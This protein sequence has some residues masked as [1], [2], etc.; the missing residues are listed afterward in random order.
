[1]VAM[2]A[3]GVCARTCATDLRRS[4]FSDGEIEPE[5]SDGVIE[6]EDT[7]PSTSLTANTTPDMVDDSSGSSTND[8][9]RTSS[10][11]TLKIALAEISVCNRSSCMGQLSDLFTRSERNLKMDTSRPGLYLKRLRESALALEDLLAD[12]SPTLPKKNYLA[13][14]NVSQLL[15][16]MLY[17]INQDDQCGTSLQSLCTNANSLIKSLEPFLDISK[18]PVLSMLNEASSICEVDSVSPR[19]QEELT[20]G[21]CLNPK[22][23]PPLHATANSD[24]WDSSVQ[25][26]VR[27]IHVSVNSA[28]PNNSVPFNGS[29][30]PCGRQCVSVGFSKN[31]H[32]AAQIVLTIT[33]I[34]SMFGALFSAVVFYFNLEN[35]GHVYVRRMLTAFTTC[36]ALAFA[37][38][39]FSARGN[40]EMICHSDG[41]L[42][43]GAPHSSFSCGFIGWYTQFF[44]SMALG[45]GVFMSYGWQNL[46]LLFSSPLSR[47]K[48]LSVFLLPARTTWWSK[49][50]L[51]V[52][53]FVVVFVPSAILS[54]AVAVQDGFD[55]CPVL[56][57]C[58]ISRKFNRYFNWY[59][60]GT[61]G[62]TSFFH[63]KGVRVLCKTYGVIGTIK[64]LRRRAGETL[65]RQ[66]VRR[67]AEKSDAAA[68]FS[69]TRCSFKRRCTLDGLKQVSRQIL[70]Y[71]L[72][73]VFVL[74]IYLYQAI[75]FEINIQDWREQENR[76]IR[77]ILTSCRPAE[78]SSL[79]RRSVLVY[80][81]R[82]SASFA[83]ILVLSTWSCS[84]T[85]LINVPGFR[86]FMMKRRKAQGSK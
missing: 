1:M 45:Y 47:P 22:C 8:G 63:F 85:Y 65:S 46:C 23:S 71:F 28:F 13:P 20:H 16:S 38:F 2:T 18:V 79:P 67:N 29:V 36:A 15:C 25:D 86:S 81:L 74:F 54:V 35:L 51:D 27:S 7:P 70:L 72:I 48:Q 83:G 73:G 68:S 49:Y 61:V 21:F 9:Q 64:W 60:I 24:H 12:V 39:I 58:V 75:S 82:L 32:R 17:Q 37:P 53:S 52:F 3:S 34:I 10:L 14:H 56:G 41:T 6:P 19:S 57:M 31:E 43:I 42:V 80:P 44:A 76:H 40:E 33:S 30:L 59:L 5:F 78:C 84:K 11:D 69:L 50:R 55:G 77:C 62:A 4:A 26:I 66:S